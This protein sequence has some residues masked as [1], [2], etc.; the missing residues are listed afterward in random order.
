MNFSRYSEWTDLF[1]TTPHKAPKE[2]ISREIWLV[3]R[4][5]VGIGDGQS[6]KDVYHKCGCLIKHRCPVKLEFQIKQW[7]KF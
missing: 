4:K 7:I 5:A 3:V 2:G 6:A 1:H